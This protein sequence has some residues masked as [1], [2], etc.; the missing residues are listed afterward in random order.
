MNLWKV[1]NKSKPKNKEMDEFERKEWKALK[2]YANHIRGICTPEF[3]W[4]K[5]PVSKKTENRLEKLGYIDFDSNSKELHNDDY[6]MTNKGYKRYQ[7]MKK[8]RYQEWVWFN[9]I[10]SIAS[11]ILNIWLFG[12]LMQWW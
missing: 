4:G 8:A 3:E 7:H 10:A 2:H 11:Y 5:Y 6:V 1:L 12:K 9:T